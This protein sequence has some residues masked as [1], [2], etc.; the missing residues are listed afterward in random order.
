MTLDYTKTAQ[1]RSVRIPDSLWNDIQTFHDKH[2][3]YNWQALSNTIR[4]L[5]TAGLEYL[6]KEVEPESPPKKRRKSPI[7]VNRP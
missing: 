7:H 4:L 6:G 3:T 5:I 1:V 2:K